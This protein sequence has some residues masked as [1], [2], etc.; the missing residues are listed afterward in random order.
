MQEAKQKE[1][2]RIEEALQ[3]AARRGNAGLLCPPSLPQARPLPC[4]NTTS[5]TG[6]EMPKIRNNMAHIRFVFFVSP[7]VCCVCRLTP[8]ACSV[9]L[10]LFCFCPAS[11]HFGMALTFFVYN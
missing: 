7:C 10:L 11:G 6:P 1:L 9:L 2:Q 8:R 4:S 5:Q 3:M